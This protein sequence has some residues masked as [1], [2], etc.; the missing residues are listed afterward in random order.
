MDALAVPRGRGGWV[1]LV[2]WVAVGLFV[3]GTVLAVAHPWLPCWRCEATL[4][5]YASG[6]P[7]PTDFPEP[8]KRRSRE[9]LRDRMNSACGICDGKGRMSWLKR[10]EIRRSPD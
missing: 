6:R 1:P 5:W 8:M 9:E 3:A 4:E 10:Q 7:V 2:L